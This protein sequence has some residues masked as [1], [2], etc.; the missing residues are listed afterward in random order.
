M[1]SLLRMYIAAAKADRAASRWLESHLCVVFGFIFVMQAFIIGMGIPAWQFDTFTL[2]SVPVVLFMLASY[3]VC[4][5]LSKAAEEV[6]S[7]Q[8]RP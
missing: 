6:I 7:E 2:L 3:F 5:L 1:K 4:E 8:H